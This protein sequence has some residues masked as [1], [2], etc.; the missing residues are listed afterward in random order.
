ML[1]SEMWRLV[2]RQLSYIT[3]QKYSGL[4]IHL[5]VNIKSPSLGGTLHFYREYPTGGKNRQQE[6]R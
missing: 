5:Y 1:S 3:T 4:H 2:V 6:R